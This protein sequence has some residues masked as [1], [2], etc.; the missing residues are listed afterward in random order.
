MWFNPCNNTVH[1][2]S[3]S[4]FKFSENAVLVE[5]HLRTHF[6]VYADDNEFRSMFLTSIRIVS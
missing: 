3:R 2:R 4:R 5:R 6:S 1:F